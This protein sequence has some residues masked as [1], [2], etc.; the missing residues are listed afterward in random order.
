MVLLYSGRGMDTLVPTL[1]ANALAKFPDGSLGKAVY[2]LMAT[3]GNLA[4][5]LEA[6]DAIHVITGL[7]PDPR[8]EELAVVYDFILRDAEEYSLREVKWKVAEFR[9]RLPMIAQKYGRKPPPN[10]TAACNSE[11]EAHFLCAQRLR[12]HIKAETGKYLHEMRVDEQLRL[13]TDLF[14]GTKTEIDGIRQEFSDRQIIIETADLANMT[15]RL[16]LHRHSGRNLDD[17][18]SN[19]PQERSLSWLF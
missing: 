6:H 19:L 13:P 4:E 17:L 11:F 7:P 3:S 5:G 1:D 2:E 18:A 8:G 16:A 14:K 15:R 9:C 12:Q 10:Y